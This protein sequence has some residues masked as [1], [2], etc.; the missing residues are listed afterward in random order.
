M[1]ERVVEKMAASHEIMTCMY[2]KINIPSA[3]LEF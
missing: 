3:V 2:R 1:L